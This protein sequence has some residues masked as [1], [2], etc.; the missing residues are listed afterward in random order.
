MRSNERSDDPAAVEP[1]SPDRIARSP[2]RTPCRTTVSDEGITPH[3]TY[4]S[5][6]DRR[7]GP[8]TPA[9]RRGGGEAG[10]R[11]ERDIALNN[12][13][14]LTNMNTEVANRYGAG[15]TGAAA[16]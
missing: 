9:A 4:T 15:A 3:A 10:R 7:T 11:P 12:Q 1:A 6:L 13:F 5:A 16:G 14:N 2:I 8:G